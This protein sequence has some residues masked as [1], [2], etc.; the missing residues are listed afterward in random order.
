M[1]PYKW[2]YNNRKRSLP[3]P[4]PRKGHVRTQRK[5]LSAGP[6]ESVGTLILG[7]HPPRTVRGE[8]LLA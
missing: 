2:P 8:L 1:G 5:W 7:F 3:V 6:A 4:M